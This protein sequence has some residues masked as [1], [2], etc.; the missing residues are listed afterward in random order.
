M[1]QSKLTFRDMQ[2]IMQN[3]VSSSKACQLTN[4][5]YTVKHAGSHLWGKRPGAYWEV[6][7][8]EVQ[9]GKYGYKYWMMFVDTFSAWTQIFL[10][11]TKTAKVRQW[12]K[13]CVKGKSG[14][15]EIDWGSLE[16]TV[17]IST[18]KFKWDRKDE[19]DTERVFDRSQD[20]FKWKL[21]YNLTLRMHPLCFT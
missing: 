3:M 16:I 17:C 10:T 13:I 6:D 18:P 20:N 1:R 2:N 7:F 12:A 8:T 21:L 5:H 15:T 4:T 19:L 14:L 9:P 11:K